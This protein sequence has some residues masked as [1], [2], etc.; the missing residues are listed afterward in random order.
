MSIITITTQAFQTFSSYRAQ[1]QLDAGSGF[2][3]IG[4]SVLLNNPNPIPGTFSAVGQATVA[5]NIQLNPGNYKIRWDP[6]NLAFG[7]DKNTGYFALNDVSLNGVTA[8]VPEPTSCLVVGLLAW[9]VHFVGVE[10]VSRTV[11]SAPSCW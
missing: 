8:A 11:V 5:L 2:A 1:V 4:S 6:R 7:T 10:N 9:A 3:D